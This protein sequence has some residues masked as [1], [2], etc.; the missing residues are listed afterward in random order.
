[1][2]TLSVLS[3]PVHSQKKV[4][5]VLSALP[6]HLHIPSHLRLRSTSLAANLYL[7]FLLFDARKPFLFTPLLGPGCPIVTFRAQT[8]RGGS[9]VFRHSLPAR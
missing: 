3:T 6:F 4:S 8:Q 9:F 2:S 1:L 5:F 7:A